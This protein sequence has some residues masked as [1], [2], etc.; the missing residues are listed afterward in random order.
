MKEQETGERRC[1]LDADRVCAQLKLP[2]KVQLPLKKEENLGGLLLSTSRF[3]RVDADLVGLGQGRAGACVSFLI[4]FLFQS[5]EEEREIGH[6]LPS[7][8]H[9]FPAP[10]G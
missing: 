2:E 6:L 8:Q 5:R 3:L 4:P 9:S 10:C 1:C 7:R